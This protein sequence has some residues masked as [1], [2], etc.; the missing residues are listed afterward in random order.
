MANDVINWV[1]FTIQIVGLL[2]I[3]I[4]LYLPP[5]AERLKTFLESVQFRLFGRPA[6]TQYWNWVAIGS[7]IAIWV[8]SVAT[9][10]LMEPSMSIVANVAFTIFTVFLGTVFFVSKVFVKLGIVLGR[11]NAIG[12]VGLVLALMGFTIELSRMFFV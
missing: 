11:G 9:V 5:L 1:S 3:T 8:I 2:L 7:Y 12:G 6:T 4:E 10:S